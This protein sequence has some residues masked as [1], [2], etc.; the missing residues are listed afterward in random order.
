MLVYIYICLTHLF[1][2]LSDRNACGA[3]I[4]YRVDHSRPWNSLSF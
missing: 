3:V 4:D 1:A 2:G